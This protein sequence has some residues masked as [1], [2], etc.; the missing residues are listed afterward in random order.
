MKL[1]KDKYFRARGSTSKLW[2]I[3][4]S[5]CNRQLCIYQKDGDGILKRLYNDRISDSLIKGTTKSMC[6]CGSLF[7]IPYI[8]QKENRP[9]IKL[10]VG[11]IRKKK[12]E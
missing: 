2:R 8:Y 9:A 1:I 12:Y 7:G 5:E 10:F 11:M 4:C 3:Y 6:E